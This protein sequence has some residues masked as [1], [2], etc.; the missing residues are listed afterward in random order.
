MSSGVTNSQDKEQ[1]CP[2]SPSAAPHDQSDTE[3]MFKLQREASQRILKAL[4][5][6]W[7]VSAASPRLG[8]PSGTSR[9]GRAVIP[10]LLTPIMATSTGNRSSPTT[11]LPP[12]QGVRDR[13]G[14][15]HRGDPLD[16]PQLAPPQAS[17]RAA[18]SV[19]VMAA[20]CTSV[21]VM[22]A[23]C[24]SVGVMAASC[25]SVGVMAASY[26][27][28]AVMAE[29]GSGSRRCHV[30]LAR[31]RLRVA[32]TPGRG[33]GGTRGEPEAPGTGGG[34]REGALG[35]SGAV[36]C[37]AVPRM[38]LRSWRSLFTG[39]LLLLTNTVSCGGLLAAGDCLQ[40]EWHRRKHPE[41]QLQLGRTGRMFVVGCSLG[42]LMHYWYLWLDSAFPARG[43]RSL[44]TVLKKVLIDQLVASPS[45]GAWYFVAIGTLEGQSLQESWDELKEKFWEFYKA[46]WSLWPAAQ[47]LN[48]LF[49]P[50]AYRVVYVNVVTLGWD[51]YL[52]YLKHRPRSSGQE[53]PRQSQSSAG[54]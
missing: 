5:T 4:G 39:R 23:S 28:V 38:L 22:A 27:A 1:Q 54:A 40:Q 36:P 34:V 33:G 31:F 43:V 51:T 15:G 8:D 17:G 30:T 44:R 32:V 26:A 50:P 35:P 12:D 18:A 7:R 2:P 20:S 19:G 45:M 53:P 47:I 46:D 11:L 9:V 52:S 48:F 3:L 37:R 13:A 42:P 10:A 29:A 41:S 21:G 14:L 16:H 25:T 6:A 24:T 49:V